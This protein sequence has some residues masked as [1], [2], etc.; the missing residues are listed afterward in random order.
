MKR[1]LY[2]CL[3]LTACSPVHKEEKL[4]SDYQ[5]ES[6]AYLKQIHGVNINNANGTFQYTVDGTTYSFTKRIPLMPYD[7]PCPIR[8]DI[9]KPERRKVDIFRTVEYGG[10]LVNYS[11]NSGCLTVYFKKEHETEN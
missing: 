11:E 2:I 3:L 9:N 1:I 6:I 10:Y 5:G 8:Y 7:F 4:Y